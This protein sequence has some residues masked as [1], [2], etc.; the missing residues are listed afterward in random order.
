MT[1]QNSGKITVVGAN[2]IDLIAYVPR[3]LNVGETLHGSEFVMGYGGKGANQ[4]VMAAKLG[5]NVVMVSKVGEDVFGGG[6]KEN[7]AKYGI[8]TRHVLSTKD[9]FSGVAPIAVV[10]EG[11]NQI[12]IVSGA[13]NLLTNAEI[14]KARVDIAESAYLVCQLE[15]DLNLTLQALRIAREVGTPTILNPAPA[16]ETLPTEIY[17]LTDIFCPN[18]TETQILTGMI[19][20]SVESAELAAKELLTRG[21]KTVL[22][23][24]GENGCLI[25]D[26]SSSTHIPAEKVNVVDTT[27]AG[28]AFVGSLAHF[29]AL[30]LSL[31]ESASRAVDVA[32][33]SV[34]KKGTQSSFPDLK[35]IPAHILAQ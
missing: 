19:I 3:F 4:A 2:M 26:S 6:T 24:L 27:G 5:S 29:L 35:E 32:S 9:A 16:V 13:N 10:P 1:P 33:I 22:I 20:N 21:V 8:D 11:Q 28:D 23:T 14:E 12:V 17:E 31:K 34:G 25:V 18:E 7:M 30:G 15:I